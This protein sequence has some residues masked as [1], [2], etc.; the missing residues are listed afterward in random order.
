MADPETQ[1]DDL[2]PNYVRSFVRQE[3]KAINRDMR[4]VTHQITTSAV[5]RAGDIVESGGAQ[6]ANFLKNPVVM[7]DHGYSIERVIGKAITIDVSEKSIVATTRFR[8]TM[9]A[10]EAFR[11]AQEGL[12]GWSIGFQPMVSHTLQDGA[13]MDCK[14]CKKRYAALAEGKSPGDY[15]PGGYSRHFMSWD[16][17]EYSSVAIPMNQDIVNNA[18][19]RGLV[20][21]ENAHMFFCSITPEPA[22]ATAA[23]L[24]PTVEAVE[25]HP[26]LAN[27]LRRADGRIG[28]QFALASVERAVREAL[29]KIHGPQ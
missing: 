24:G 18:I 27:A 8:D 14:T 3:V 6:V 10:D 25:M 11:L 1:V 9:L 20:S 13:K 2:R 5:D 23:A 7:A 22:V 19:A 17:L 26:V 4:E 28:K 21:R 16:L 12:G 29:E 15:V